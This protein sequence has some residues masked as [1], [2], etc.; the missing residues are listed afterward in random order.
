VK[1]RSARTRRGERGL[2]LRQSLVTF[3]MRPDRIASAFGIGQLAVRVHLVTQPV[4]G[5]ANF[6]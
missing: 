1:G 4:E 5:D 2:K 6:N 3:A